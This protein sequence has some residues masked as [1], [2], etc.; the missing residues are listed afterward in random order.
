[1]QLYVQDVLTSIVVPN[2]LLKG[3]AKVAIKAGAT[4]TVEI[5]VDVSKLGLWN[6]KMQYVVEPGDFLV[7]VGSSSAD[8]RSNATLTVDA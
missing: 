4:A 2:I 3:F 1:M 6:I 7:Y 5:P 8:L